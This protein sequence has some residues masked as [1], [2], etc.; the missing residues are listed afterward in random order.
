MTSRA[1]TMVFARYDSKRLPGKALRLIGGM[2]LLER[3]IR[4]AQLLPWPVYLATTDKETDG[5]LV[6]LADGLGVRA[7]RGSENR[8]LERAVLAGE[9]FELDFFARLCGDRPLFPMDT[10][11]HAVAAMQHVGDISEC[12][13]VPDLVTNCLGGGV[14]RGLTTE[15]VRTKTLR[16]IL[17]RGVSAEQQEHLTRYLYEH[18]RQFNI[19]SLPHST[20]VYDCPGFA[21]DTEDDLA[22]LNRV[23]TVCGAIDMTVEQADRIYSS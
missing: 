6:E 12:T 23:F 2:P 14:A 7:F 22:T 1:G 19:L 20:A 18:Q 21:V 3:V 13:A 16:R 11:R 15:V 17:N 4:R 5:A 8:V 9:A 10:F